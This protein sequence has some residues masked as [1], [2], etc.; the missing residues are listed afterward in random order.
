[1]RKK[2]RGKNI[3]FDEVKLQLL[4]DN[5]CGC[6]Y[7]ENDFG[8]KNKDAYFTLLAR[9]EYDNRCYLSNPYAHLKAIIKERGIIDV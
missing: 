2:F 6:R 4:S 3:S 5:V 1:M 8:G 9:F 7:F